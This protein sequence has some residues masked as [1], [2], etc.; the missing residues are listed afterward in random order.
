MEVWKKIPN[1]EGLYDI[2]SLGRVKSVR[3]NKI[4]KPVLNSKYYQVSLSNDK[5][6]RIHQLMAITFLNHIPDGTM[7]FI[8]D[9]ING[10]YL[11]NRLENLQV[12]TQK[13]NCI[14]KNTG[15]FYSVSYCKKYNKWKV[16]IIVLKKETYLEYFTNE[17]EAHL[18][19][20][21]KL[22]EII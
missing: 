1:Y 20:Q 4:L 3:K 15:N 12:T 17:E 16:L 11:D 18:A 14:R 7:K 2:S 19:Y 22:K 13:Q 21:N 8:V 5:K 10:D 6:C 9:H